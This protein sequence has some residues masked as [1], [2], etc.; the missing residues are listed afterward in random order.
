MP[1]DPIQRQKVLDWLKS[2]SLSPICPFCGRDSWNLGD[3][4]APYNISALRQIDHTS[5]TAMLP[6]IC[7][8]CGH[9]DLFS[10]SA[11]KLL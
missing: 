8:N 10:A 2:K 6:L 3:L 4:I 7:T 9:I 1:L 5:A 11:M